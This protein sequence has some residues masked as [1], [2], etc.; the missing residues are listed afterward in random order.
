MEALYLE[1]GMN[2]MDNAGGKLGAILM[3]IMFVYCMSYAVGVIA[4]SH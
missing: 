3:F 4:G 2:E 1:G